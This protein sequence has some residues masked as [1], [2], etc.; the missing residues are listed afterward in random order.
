MILPVGAS[1][2]FCGFVIAHNPFCRRIKLQP[3]SDACGDV[4]QMHERGGQVTDFNIGVRPRIVFDAL[5]KIAMMC[6]AGRPGSNGRR[7]ARR[8]AKF[9]RRKT[10]ARVAFVDFMV[11]PASR[12]NI[13]DRAYT[14]ADKR[15][16]PIQMR[17]MGC[18]MKVS[19]LCPDPI[20]K[21]Y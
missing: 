9:G 20:K 19:P 1:Y 5:Q 17:Q 6:R 10:V 21:P 11:L 16:C 2:K 8:H 4:S 15:Q 14:K 7:D 3:P 13:L 18:R 12:E